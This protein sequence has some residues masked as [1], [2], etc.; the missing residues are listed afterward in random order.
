MNRSDIE[1]GYILINSAGSEY[2]VVNY[3][4]KRRIV[5]TNYISDAPIDNM[6]DTELNAINNYISF[7]TIKDRNDNV[8]WEKP[9]ELT[10]QE[11]ADKFG[12]PVEQ[13]RIKE[14]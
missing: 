9:V 11:I 10:M 12:I 14:S 3:K 4:N 8:I 1:E 5:N 13:L 6:M 2:I 7:E